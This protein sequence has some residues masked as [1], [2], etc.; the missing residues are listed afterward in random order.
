MSDLSLLT[1]AS[2]LEILVLPSFDQSSVLMGDFTQVMQQ[3]LKS[4]FESPA[5]FDEFAKSMKFQPETRKVDQL[6]YERQEIFD[7][8]LE[9]ISKCAPSLS[10]SSLLLRGYRE[11]AYR[12]VLNFMKIMR[13][14]FCHALPF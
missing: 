7:P 5:T 10:D 8:S 9:Y 14:L 2:G 4:R 6:G 3:K 12:F 11:D 13:H 1:C